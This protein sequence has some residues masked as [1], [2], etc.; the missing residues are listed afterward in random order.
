MFFVTTARSTT[1]KFR[2]FR[3]AAWQ[4]VDFYRLATK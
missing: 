1:S 2:A 3:V 4:G